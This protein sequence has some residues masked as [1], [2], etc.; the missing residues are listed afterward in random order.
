[1]V[2]VAPKEEEEEEGIEMLIGVNFFA[3]GEPEEYFKALVQPTKIFSC[4]LFV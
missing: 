1:M 2:A 3:Y 4:K